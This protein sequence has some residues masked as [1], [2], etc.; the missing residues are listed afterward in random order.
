[1]CNLTMYP[2]RKD[3]SVR[4]EEISGASPTSHR[5]RSSIERIET[6]TGS[7]DVRT[8]MFAA[9]ADVKDCFQVIRTPRWMHP[10]FSCPHSPFKSLMSSARYLTASRLLA[11]VDDGFLLVVTSGAA[12]R[13]DTLFRRQLRYH[14]QPTRTRF[15]VPGGVERRVQKTRSAPSGCRRY[16]VQPGSARA[17]SDLENRG[18]RTTRVS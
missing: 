14:Q 9:T 7:N 10:F 4:G 13:Q 15:C 16:P 6:Q 1:M 2:K 5:G 18:C 12:S 8:T 3:R 17:E 11:R